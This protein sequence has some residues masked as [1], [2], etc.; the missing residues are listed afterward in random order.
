[1]TVAGDPRAVRAAA[2]TWLAGITM[3]GQVEVTREQLANDFAVDGVRFPLID[4][5][6]GIRKPLGWDAA[7][8]ITTAVPK[9]G[10]LRP[11]DDA[12]GTDGLYR[13][14]LRRDAGGEAENAGLREAMRQG[15]PL[16]WFYGVAPGVFQAVFPVY[17]VAEEAAQD[18]FVLA[19]TDDQREI[20]PGSIVEGALRRYIVAQTRRRL[21]QPVFA[22][23]VM[24]A[25]TTRCAVCDLNHRRLLDAAHI[26]PDTAPDGEPVVANGLALCKI[27]HAAYDANVLG[28]RPDYVVQ[29]HH[30][31]LAEID[32]PMLRHG[33]QGHHDQSL[34]RIPT[35]RA[36]RPDPAR[37]ARRYDQFRAA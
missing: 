24:L 14:K 27:H 29:I 25:Y 31:L 7:L 36:D 9:S 2:L 30:R 10:R 22:S 16:A 17:L 37:L 6:R 32:G 23:Q 28:I 18:Q 12:E 20:A 15:L 13:Y 11:Y 19:L 21:H 1:V 26:I 34:M 5:G 8:S 3:D 4:R 33:L 35:R